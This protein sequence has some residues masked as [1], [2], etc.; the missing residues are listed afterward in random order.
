[1]TMDM[2]E[3][4]TAMQNPP[5]ATALPGLL[6][7]INCLILLNRNTT[8][9]TVGEGEVPQDALSLLVAAHMPQMLPLVF[10]KIK[11]A[12]CSDRVALLA[13]FATKVLLMYTFC[14]TIRCF[15]GLTF[16]ST[17]TEF[18]INLI[19]LGMV[20]AILN[21]S[22]DVHSTIRTRRFSDFEDVMKLTALACIA[23]V[24]M[25]INESFKYMLIDASNN[26]ETLAFMPAVWMLN[27]LDRNAEVFAPIPEQFSHGQAVHFVTFLGCFYFIED[28]IRPLMILL[29]YSVPY[30]CYIIH[31]VFMLDFC[32]FFICQT[33]TSNQKPAVPL[34]P[35][36]GM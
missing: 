8:V 18:A 36:G 13:R 27:R 12:S 23:A 31:L 21:M 33:M 20:G 6:L 3:A 10:F 19:C 9:S 4:L 2:S 29:H 5:F 26:V 28:L 22:H 7:L 30:W 15:S 1:M 25:N 11:V 14:F 34:Q 24:V 17:G 16:N 32:G 35:S